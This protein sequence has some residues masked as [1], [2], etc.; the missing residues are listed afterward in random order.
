M[1]ERLEQC[2]TPITET[3][4]KNKLPLFSRLPVNVQS[5]QKAQL[6]LKSD[7]DLFIR[8]YISCQTRDGHIDTFFAYENQVFNGV[9]ADLIRCLEADFPNKMACHLLMK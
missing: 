3:L 6:A 8:L 4:P 1:T 7:C 5:K 9:K 2:K